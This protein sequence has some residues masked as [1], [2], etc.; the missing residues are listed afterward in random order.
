MQDHLLLKTVFIGI[1]NDISQSQNIFSRITNYICGDYDNKENLEKDFQSIVDKKIQGVQQEKRSNF[2]KEQK[3]G[4]I[5][6]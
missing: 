6:R 4:I 2:K 1:V 5:M 3:S